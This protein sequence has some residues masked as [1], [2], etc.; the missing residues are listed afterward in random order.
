MNM[1]GE[2]ILE[3]DA[4]VLSFGKELSAGTYML[5]LNYISGKQDVI[6]IVKLR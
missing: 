6:K 4:S 3:L 5:Q 1:M 2:K